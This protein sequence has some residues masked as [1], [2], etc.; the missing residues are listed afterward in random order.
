M[1]SGKYFGNLLNDL[2]KY[3]N[4]I[5]FFSLNFISQIY[6]IVMRRAM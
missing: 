4:E 2:L 5:F 1:F 3:D 6:G